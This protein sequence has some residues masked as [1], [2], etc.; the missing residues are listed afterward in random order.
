VIVIT[1]LLTVIP[2]SWASVKSPVEKKKE[3]AVQQAAEVKRASETAKNTQS[4]SQKMRQQVP[5]EAIKKAINILQAHCP[6]E[7]LTILQGGEPGLCLHPTEPLSKA[8]RE[9]QIELAYQFARFIL[10]RPCKE[11]GFDG[12]DDATLD[13]LVKV[14][15]QRVDDH[16]LTLADCLKDDEA[17]RTQMSDYMRLSCPM[18]VTDFKQ[19]VDWVRTRNMQIPGFVHPKIKGAL[20]PKKPKY[21]L[22]WMKEDGHIK[23]LLEKPE[24]PSVTPSRKIS[25]P[26]AQSLS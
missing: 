16:S 4:L 5:E 11:Q 3:V 14:P 22:H 21:I 19:L 12:F 8:S 23:T 7:Y 24:N 6:C 20:E 17:Y 18:N 10:K 25:R 9:T 1:L 2:A 26:S 15:M 13:L